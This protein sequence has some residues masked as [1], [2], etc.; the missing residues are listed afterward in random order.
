MPTL[1]FLY[2]PDAITLILLLVVF[3]LLRSIAIDHIRQELLM[4]RKEMLFYWVNN[5]LDPKDRGYLAL[6]NLI[7]SSTRVLPRLS[8][9]RLMFIYLLK[10]KAAKRGIMVPLPDPSGEC[11]LMIDRSANTNGRKKLKRLHMEMNL[12]LGMFFLLGSL[13]SWFPAFLI[14]P[15]MLKRT[16]SHHQ[17]HRTDFFFDML[18]RVLGSLGRQALQIGCAAQSSRASRRNQRSDEKPVLKNP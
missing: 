16:I 17:D 15:R 14:I 2:L 13:S 18:E 10:R 7:E 6:R 5:G 1:P 4:I 12:A 8:P 11:S 3:S 9:G